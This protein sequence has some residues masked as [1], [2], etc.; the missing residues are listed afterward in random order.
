MKRRWSITLLFFTCLIISIVISNIHHSN[1]KNHLINPSNN[2]S[3]IHIKEYSTIAPALTVIEK[4]NRT[5]AGQTIIL[6][7][8]ASSSTVINGSAYAVLPPSW[9]GNKIMVN[10]YNLY[11]NRCWSLNPEFNGP[12]FLGISRNISK[13]FKY[14]NDHVA[15]IRVQ[16]GSDRIF[17]MA[18]TFGKIT[19]TTSNL[20]STEI[21]DEVLNRTLRWMGLDTSA[22]ILILQDDLSSTFHQAYEQS[23][24]RLGYITHE[25]RTAINNFNQISDR[26]LVIWC[27]AEYNSVEDPPYFDSW[28]RRYLGQTT[29]GNLIHSGEYV[30]F[31]MDEDFTDYG[32]TDITANHYYNDFLMANFL[33]Y[34][35]ES[36]L[37]EGYTG[38]TIGDNL[39]FFINGTG[40]PLPDKIMPYYRNNECLM[41]NWSSYQYGNQYNA[42]WFHRREKDGHGVNDDC[43]LLF[44]EDE[45]DDGYDT[46]DKVWVEQELYINRSEIIWAGIN[47]DY[48]TYNTWGPYTG[49]FRIYVSINDTV[50]YTKPLSI[51]EA[52]QRWFNTGMI[53]INISAIPLPRISIKIGLEVVYGSNY[54]PDIKPMVMIDNFKLYLQTKVSPSQLNLKMDGIPVDG[55][56]GYGNCTLVPTAPWTNSPVQVNFTWN[57]NPP[58]NPNLDIVVTFTCDTNLFASKTGETL[59]TADPSK[60]GVQLETNHGTNTTWYFQYL[61]NIPTGYWNHSFSIFHPS[62]WVF[63]FVSEP[64]LPSINK[65][66]ECISGTEN[67]TVPATTITNS[68]DGYWRFE[69]ISPNYIQIIQPQIFNG[70]HW[71][72][73]SHFRVTNLTRIICHIYNG[74]GPPP[75]LESSSINLTIID[76][77]NQF[78]YTNT[79]PLYNDGWAIFPNLTIFGDN[80]TGGLYKISISWNNGQEAGYIESNFSIIHSTEL[81]LSRPIDAI[82]DQTTEINYGELLL[83]RIGLNDTDRNQLVKGI[84]LTLNW[85]EN[86]IPVLKKLNDLETGQ[87]E[88]V[89]DTSDLPAISNYTIIIN[90]SSSFFFNATYTLNLI[91]TAET[92][93]TSPQY[94]KIV[95]EWGSIVTIQ[96]E[97]LRALD[98]IGINNSLVMVNWTLGPYTVTELGHGIY[99]IEINL[100]F[101]E[102]HEYLLVINATKANCQFQTLDIK[103]EVTP[104]ETELLSDDYPHT[105]SEWGKNLTIT[106]NYRTITSIGINHSLISINWTLG[107]YSINEGGNGFYQ[108][109]LNTSWCDIREYLLIINASKIYHNNKSLQILIQINIVE[110][111][112]IYKSIETIA[113]GQNASISLKYIEFAGAP[114]SPDGSASDIFFVNATHWVFYNPLEEYPYTI[115]I[116]TVGLQE[117]DIIN[118]TATKNYYKSQSIYIFL[119]YRP[120][121]TSL[122]NLNETLITMPI[123]ERASILLYYNDTEYNVG[124]ENADITFYGYENISFV[125]LGSG[126]YKI[127]IYAGTQAE[128][129]TILVTINKTGYLGNS[130]QFILQIKEWFQFTSATF[131]SEVITRSVGE[132]AS[133]SVILKNEFSGTYFENVTVTYTWDSIKGNLTYIGNGNYTFVIDTS[134]MAPGTYSITINATTKNGDLLITKTVTLVIVG[135]GIS[136]FIR[137]SWI[138]GIIGAVVAIYS[139]YT[140]RNRLRQRNWERNVKH[141]YV[142]TKT[143]IPLYD[144]RLGGTNAPEP[145]LVTSALIGISSIIQEIVHSERELKT[146]D[147]M[148][149]KIL[150]SHGQHVIVAIL[151]SVDFPIIRKRLDQFTNRFEY[152]FRKELENWKGDVDV[153]FGANKLV[154]EFFPLEE[155]LDDK[156]LT[157]EWLLERISYIHGLSGIVTLLMIE[158]GLKTPKKIAAGVGIKEKK[159]LSILKT[160]EDLV[161][162]DS[163]NNLTNLGKEVINIY[164]TRKEKYLSILKLSKEKR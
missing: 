87:Y 30:G 13:V 57:P 50:V 77:N 72:N 80:T 81:V 82:E 122:V 107:Y 48:W 134:N 153:F 127:E 160:L 2:H 12:E 106:I 137:Y 147:H 164:K 34:I 115:L 75:N 17:Y 86:G 25:T 41:Y 138:F 58:P 71:I 151:S 141:I 63:T 33:D 154:N 123:N 128:S 5:D 89:L 42:D 45:T 144:K 140:I 39:I 61:V 125:N 35:S 9:Q 16:N 31:S 76:P 65:L 44:I 52:H 19:N 152:H 143:G 1:L 84:D 113:Y 23:L 148:D 70:S 36:N 156:D 112:L 162:I 145:S 10:I 24:D 155:Y 120:I 21:Q 136:W 130:I 110:T 109:T 121:L 118:I 142:L 38:D 60:I 131:S 43:L 59:Y 99:T 119:S 53:P 83:I 150:F 73:S 3:S 20:N 95:K 49:N 15:A 8:N 114:I 163:G 158:L 135:G 105:S 94:P 103:L 90:S 157:T 32:Y 62:D 4:A 149:N 46:G 64:Q 29:A 102:L 96:V 129:H 97:Y 101:A 104:I 88:I 6:R 91:V 93:L 79:T 11:E 132:L 14:G 67:F 126:Y 54:G 55:G 40:D 56:I 22:D 47:F 85:T 26:D 51:I 161:L 27:S 111:K 139:G 69:A 92:L 146:I 18:F 159:V 78:W 28:V 116:S 7:Y 108:I 98:E 117:S 37:T 133:F 100:S 124:V 66:N 68:P 74:T